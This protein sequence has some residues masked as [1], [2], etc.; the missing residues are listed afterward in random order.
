MKIPYFEKTAVQTSV[1]LPEAYIIP[2]EWRVLIER[3]KLHGIR[4]HRLTKETDVKVTT[5]RFSNPKWQSNP[6]E[7]RHPL[8]SFDMEE[9]E[10]NRTYPLGSAVIDMNQPS[11]GVIAHI[12]EPK[13]NGSYL[14]WGFFDAIFEQKEYAENYVM[15]ELAKKMLAETP[16]LKDELEKKK[17]EDKAFA[18][19]PD[20][21]L[22]WFFSKTPFWDSRKNLYPVGRIMD[23]KTVDEII[24][25]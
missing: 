24:S 15:E 5:Y 23:R 7:G 20:A 8:T 13:G 6:Y 16:A 21:I 22:N 17:K 3:M 14:Y 11:A 2:T 1:K 18:A 10:I 12:L 4:I 9:T 25:K 19:N